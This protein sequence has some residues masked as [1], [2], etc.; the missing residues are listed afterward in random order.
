M[1]AGPVS[2]RRANPSDLDAINQVIEAAVMGW[3]LPERVKRLSLPSYRY[4]PFDFEHLDMVVAEDSQ[5]RI[6]GV[7]A[8]EPAAA[9][10]TPAGHVALLLHGIYVDPARQGQ[11]IGRQ[12]F[13]AA[14][15]AARQHGYDG[16]LVKAQAD[17]SDFFLTQGM[18]RL[19]VEDPSRQYTNRFWKNVAARKQ[20]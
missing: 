12:L 18:A 5:G 9:K 14:E 19:P 13:Q 4:T 3:D 16:L 8:W 10:E 2:L 20:D 17:A 11:G 1:K 7:A 6:V 15:D